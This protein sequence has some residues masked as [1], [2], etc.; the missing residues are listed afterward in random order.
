MKDRTDSMLNSFLI[1]IGLLTLV[2]PWRSHLLLWVKKFDCLRLIAKSSLPEHFHQFPT[3][4]GI[5]GL[6]WHTNGRTFAIF[7]PL[8]NTKITTFK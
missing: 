2:P 8:K 5:Y 6:F 4:V 1:Y 7:N 3:L